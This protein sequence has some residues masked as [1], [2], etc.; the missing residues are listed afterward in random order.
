MERILLSPITFSSYLGGMILFTM[1]SVTLP[2]LLTLAVY[3][4][5][6]IDIGFSLA[7]YAGL[8]FVLSLFAPAFA[9]F[10]N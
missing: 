4:I 8:L 2:A 6:G 7:V 9:L 1:L 3:C 10:L 5:V